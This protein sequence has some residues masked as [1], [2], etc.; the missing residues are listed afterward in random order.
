MGS[1]D[2]S[3]SLLS[4]VLRL[5]ESHFDAFALI[6]RNLPSEIRQSVAASCSLARALNNAAVKTVRLSATDGPVLDHE[7]ATVFPHATA[8]RLHIQEDSGDEHDDSVLTALR[9]EN[10]S[11]VTPGLLAG[12]EALTIF[13]SG[14]SMEDELNQELLDLLER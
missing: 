3:S 2:A 6:R 10:W 9:L 14:Y 7:L 8:L 4:K 11:A 5:G 1:A 13:M 12:L